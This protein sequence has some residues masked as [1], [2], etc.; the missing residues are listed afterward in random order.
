MFDVKKNYVIGIVL[1]ENL[2]ETLLLKRV[3]EPFPDTLNGIG[4][5]INS[6]ESLEDAM[7][8]EMQEETDIKIENVK[9]IEYMLTEYYPYGVLLNV[10]SIILNDSYEKKELIKT[11]EG[12]L[13]W[14]NL[15][16]HNLFD[17]RKPHMAGEG[18][19]SFFIN[20]ALCKEGIDT[21][22]IL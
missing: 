17:T 15:V 8:R 10:F 9:K 5:K 11:R 6:D 4:G 12:E 3:K 13:R 1:D 7:L 19:V 22:K 20:Y 18:N 2:T 16:E 21:S 14:Y